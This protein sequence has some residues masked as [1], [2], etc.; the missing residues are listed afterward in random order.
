M[1]GGEQ[2]F[3]R[4]TAPDIKEVCGLE[5]SVKGGIN[6]RH[7][8]ASAVS[9]GCRVAPFVY[10]DEVRFRSS[11]FELPVVAERSGIIE[12]HFGVAGNEFIILG[13]DERVDFDQQGV[14][15]YQARLQVFDHVL[16]SEGLLGQFVVISQSL[17][18]RIG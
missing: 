17:T 8:Q 6:R 1:K 10:G 11:F 15:S 2:C 13:E 3:G 5:S 9:D 14:V 4:C 18:E 16:Q 7:R 12:C